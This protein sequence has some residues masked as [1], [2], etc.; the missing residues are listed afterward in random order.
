[1]S[2]Q[3]GQ[4]YVIS[5]IEQTV[6]G[7][8]VTG[9][10]GKV[11]RTLASQAFTYD[12]ALIES[13]E[14]RPD[15]MYGSPKKGVKSVPGAFSSELSYGTF[16]DLFQALL[17]NTFSAGV[18]TPGTTTKAFTF[19]EYLQDIDVTMQVEWVRVLGMNLNIPAEGMVQIGW[20]LLGRSAAKIASGASPSLTSPTLTTTKP[21]AGVDC[22]IVGPGSAQYSAVTVGCARQG[23]VQ[24]LIGTKLSPDVY[25]G[26]AKGTGTI[27]G[28]VESLAWLDEVD[29]DTGTTLTATCPDDD[30]NEIEIAL[31][32]VQILN[33]SP[34]VGA[35]AAMIQSA[36]FAFGGATAIQI[37]NTDAA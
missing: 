29:G 8:P 31:S 20:N 18:L 16:D 9:A 22:T 27:Q 11:L 36:N 32:G 7:T 30:G 1:M 6:I 13:Q 2:S 23:G 35:P 3:S 4:N 34:P 14:L 15:G 12:R 5:F 24:P 37:T 26:A 28:T 17:R 10:G 21:I 33:F 19:D 25:H